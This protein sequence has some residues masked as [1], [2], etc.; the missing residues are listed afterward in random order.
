MVVLYAISVLFYF[1][2]FL[3]SNRKANRFAFRLLLIVWILQTMIFIVHMI[4]TGRFPILTI[5]EGL[6][7]YVWLLISM[8]LFINR[9]FRTDFFVFFANLLGFCM[10]VLHTFAPVQTQGDIVAEKLISELLWIHIS[11]SLFSYGA[12][13]LAFVFSLLYLLQYHL[14]KQ[15]KWGKQLIRTSHL[16]KLE[17]MSYILNVIGVPL[18]LIG[19]ILGLQWAYIKI[20]GLP[21]LDWKIIGSFVMLT[22]YGII[23]FLKIRKEMVGRNLALLNVVAFFLLLINFFLMSR[24]STFHLW[25]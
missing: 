16:S 17:Q 9:F 8:S 10:M 15:K 18:L 21:I 4:Q 11:V 19:V 24:L 22:V 7:F 3:Q 25:Y 23:L 5:F 12:F 6:Y 1:I 20:P 14:L 13:S 2:D